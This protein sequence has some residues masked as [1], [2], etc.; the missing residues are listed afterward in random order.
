MIEFLVLKTEGVL[1]S[2]YFFKRERVEN[3]LVRFHNFYIKDEKLLVRFFIFYRK[4]E[5]LLI[6]FYIF[7]RKDE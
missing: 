5:N 4:G 2:L 1:S 7:L 3:L 6:R